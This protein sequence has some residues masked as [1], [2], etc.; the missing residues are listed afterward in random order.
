ML[1]SR[2]GRKISNSYEK[3]KRKFIWIQA[4]FFSNLSESRTNFTNL[5]NLL[6]MSW[7]MKIIWIQRKMYESKMIVWFYQSIYFTV[8]H[9]WH[10][11]IKNWVRYRKKKSY[12]MWGRK[13][14]CIMKKM[15]DFW[16]KCRFS[17]NCQKKTHVAWRKERRYANS[18]IWLTLQFIHHSI[19][20]H[21]RIIRS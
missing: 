6:K 9:F 10:F 8:F 5:E 4:N 16:V 20:N 21:P 15:R 11:N 19:D 2:L 1:Y 18:T 12:N 17:L 3:K 7:M 13:G 14:R